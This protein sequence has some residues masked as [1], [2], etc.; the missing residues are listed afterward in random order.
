MDFDL[1]TTVDEYDNSTINLQELLDRIFFTNGR[2]AHHERV[3]CWFPKYLQYFEETNDTLMIH[4]DVLPVTW[5][6]YIAIMAISCYECEYL[7]KLLEEQFLLNGG[8]VEW[9]TKGL[10]KIDKKLERLSTLNEY[11]AYKP[12]IITLSVVEH[13]LKAEDHNLIWS[14]PE[15]L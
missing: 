13:L 3:L 11:M 8:N 6:Y 1:S 15:L 12:W 14:I 4:E 9:L 2:L 5:K 7:L 10:K